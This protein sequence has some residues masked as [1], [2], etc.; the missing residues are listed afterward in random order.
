MFPDHYLREENQISEDN[1]YFS[2]SLR[3]GQVAERIHLAVSIEEITL[4]VE[5]PWIY[6]KL[7]FF[8]F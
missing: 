6:L 5:C 2:P 4:T 1:V 8:Y 7:Q 3:K